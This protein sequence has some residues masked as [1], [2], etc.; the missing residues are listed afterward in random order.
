MILIVVP[1]LDYAALL[2]LRAAV[3][4]PWLEAY[5]GNVRYW[6]PSLAEADRERAALAL[7]GF[8]SQIERIDP[9]A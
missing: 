6:V 8:S 3:A 2:R 4:H 9:P 5:K 1:V 7:V